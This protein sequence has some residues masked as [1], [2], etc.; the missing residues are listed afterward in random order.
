MT[1]EQLFEAH[2]APPGFKRNPRLKLDLHDEVEVLDTIQ[3]SSYEPQKNKAMVGKVGVVVGR[4]PATQSL[5]IGVDFGDGKEYKFNSHYLQLVGGNAPTAQDKVKDTVAQILAKSPELFQAYDEQKH[6]AAFEI[7]KELAAKNSYTAKHA[8]DA[9]LSPLFVIKLPANITF[10]LR[11]KLLPTEVNTMK[12]Y[13]QLGIFVSPMALSSGTALQTGADGATIV[14]LQVDTSKQS[15][16][17]NCLG[18]TEQA[19]T[20]S[21]CSP[22]EFL[23]FTSSWYGSSGT[24]N[25]DPIYKY[26]INAIF[27]HNSDLLNRLCLYPTYLVGI[28]QY[29]GFY[30]QLNKTNIKQ[31]YDNT[32][33]FVASAQKFSETFNANNSGLKVFPRSGLMIN[34]DQ[35]GNVA[36][37]SVDP[38]VVFKSNVNGTEIEAMLWANGSANADRNPFAIFASGD[39]V[40]NVSTFNGED[41][42]YGNLQVNESQLY[43]FQIHS[44]KLIFD[45]LEGRYNAFTYITLKSDINI[46]GWYGF[47]SNIVNLDEMLNNSKGRIDLSQYDV[48]FKLLADIVQHLSI[49]VQECIV[50]ALQS[51]NHQNIII[52]NK[53]TV[54]IAD[55]YNEV[56]NQLK[57]D[58]GDDMY[59]ISNAF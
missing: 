43:A 46:N 13:S 11:I 31:I 4:Y 47:G 32:K 9:T 3:T 44:S 56:Q 21:R 41:V 26:V 52:M 51:K 53:D 22:L 5:K 37:N 6:A 58:L 45:E 19:N 49:D 50:L 57:Q 1:F 28:G 15:F 7:C 54:K 8:P 33:R 18:C 35:Q 27:T 10:Y 59:D 42:M 30:S 17:V 23:T 12:M 29:T 20:Y 38:S 40:V 14:V 2:V 25:V 34:F 36:S 55:R 39:N 16:I 48:V 24:R